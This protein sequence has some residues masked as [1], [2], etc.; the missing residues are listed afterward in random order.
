MR[1]LF[2]APAP[3]PVGGIESVTDN[4]VN[5]LKLNKNGTDLILFNTSHRYRPVTSKSLL[6]RLYSGVFNSLKTY[7][8][9]LSFIKKDKPDIIHL[10][11]SAS[12]ALFKDLLIVIAANRSR[13]PIVLH[14]HFGR[15]PFLQ[16]KR[17]WE[18][19]VIRIVICKSTRSIVID[20]KSYAILVNEGFSNIVNIPNPLALD[21]EDKTRELLAKSSQ[22]VQ[23]RLIYVGHIIKDKGVFELVEA[24]SQT[25][26]IKEVILIGPYE[27]DVKDDLLKIAKERFATNWL[28]FTGGLEIN[29]VLEYMK[30]SPVLVLPSYTEGFPMVILEA[31][32]MGCAIIATDV[33]AIPEMLGINT[34]TPCG[35]CIPP[36]NVEKLR[37]AILNLTENQYELERFGSKGMKRV[38]NYYT[39]EKVFMQYKMIWKSAIKQ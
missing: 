14:W 15:I 36:Q 26:M 35:I 16:K 32:A 22:R 7:F 31:M 4:L 28:K 25:P 1:V 34:T 20:S 38:L 13:I 30:H 18:W 9:V 10:A 33:G 21:I 8:K 11:S 2:I 27:K 3:P 29:Q 5:Y 39:M 19:R 6:I 17:N 23:G 37:D 12:L 24:C